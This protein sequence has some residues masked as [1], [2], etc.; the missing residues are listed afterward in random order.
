MNYGLVHFSCW[1]LLIIL[2]IVAV[3]F[4][5]LFDAFLEKYLPEDLLFFLIRIVVLDIVVRGLV[6]DE[7]A[8][9]V[10]IRIFVPDPSVLLLVLPTRAMA[11]LLAH[12][13][14]QE[15]DSLVKATNH[16][17]FH[18]LLVLLL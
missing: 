14:S 12:L 3:P 13:R 2:L 15:Q 7:V 6:E 4:F 16:R 1:G 18:H 11:A 17:Y 10:T 9:M 8:V 5:F